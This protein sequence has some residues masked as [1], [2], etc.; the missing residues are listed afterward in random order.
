MHPHLVEDQTERLLEGLREGMLDAAV[1]ALPSGDKGLAEI[2]LFDEDFV[3]VVPAEHP[4]AGRTDVSA[5]VVHELPLL[6]LDEGHCLR[7]R[8]LDLCRMGGACPALGGTRATALTPLATCV[9]SG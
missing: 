3:L 2:E 4:L 1:I 7:G 9:C 5:E 8:T 6:L